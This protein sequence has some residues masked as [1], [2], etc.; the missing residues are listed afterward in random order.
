[1]N[2]LISQ[3]NYIPWKGYFDSIARCDVFVVFDDMQYTR[4]DWRN[5]NLIKTPQ[6]LKWLT[7]PVDVKGKYFQK[8]R[9]T[10]IAD[11][12]WTDSHWGS[13]RQ[14]Y[15]DAP[16]FKEMSDWVEPL[17][18]NCNYDFLSEVNLH[19]IE[20]INDFLGIDTEIRQSSEFDLHEDKTQRLVNICAELG[21]TRYLSGAAAKAYMEPERFQNQGIEL[22]YFDYGGYP[23]Y[24]QLHGDFEHGVTILDVIFNLGAQTASVLKYLKK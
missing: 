5:R 16:H 7:I 20:A 21:A 14:N 4:R 6:G 10:R 15:K 23:E 22:E 3:S 13:L 2:V 1:M 17:Y 9:E 11:K 19:F 12:G 24:P 18:R 8:I